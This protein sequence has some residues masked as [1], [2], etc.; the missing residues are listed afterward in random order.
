MSATVKDVAARAGVSPKTVSN[1]LSGLVGV[2]APVRERVERAVAELDYVPNLSARRLRSGR[3]GVIALALP[4]LS[5]PYSAEMAH[6]FV[7][8]AHERG[9][10]VQ[11]EESG[12]RPDRE[13]SLLS[14]ARAR[15]V[16]GLILNPTVV[17]ELPL[18]EA[19]DQMPPTVVIGEVAHQV[20]DQVCVDSEQAA[21]DM[22]TYLIEAGHERIAVV[23]TSADTEFMTSVLRARGYRRALAAAGLVHDPV[24]EIACDDWTPHGGAVAVRAFLDSSRTPDAIFCFTDSLAIGVL[25]ELSRRGISVPQGVSVSGFDDVADGEYA[26]P[27]L[28]TVSF[29]KPRFA[30]AALERLARRISAPYGAEDAPV[31]IP[32][33]HRIVVRAS[34]RRA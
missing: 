17:D 26:S 9:W 1:V 29:D 4:D 13:A 32:V 25:S 24:L 18:T 5:T 12:G 16:D 33:E 23:G 2:S 27:P 34:T 14:R 3:S 28:T 22:T 21:F 6:H 15:M 30:A 20:F 19:L 7:E 31:V 10:G 8:A 11:I